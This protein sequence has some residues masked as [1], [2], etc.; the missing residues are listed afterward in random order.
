MTFDSIPAG[1]LIQKTMLHDP[2]LDESKVN[3]AFSHSG[4]CLAL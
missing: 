3:L 4:T 2:A 1:E